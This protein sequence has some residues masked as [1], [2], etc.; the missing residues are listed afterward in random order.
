[1]KLHDGRFIVELNMVCDGLVRIE[2]DC[3]DHGGVLGRLG[4][5]RSHA[6]GH[7][8]K[9]RLWIFANTSS[10]KSGACIQAEADRIARQLNFER[11]DTILEVRLNGIYGCVLLSNLLRGMMNKYR[12]EIL[13]LAHALICCRREIDFSGIR[14][15]KK[16]ARI[17]RLL[18]LVLLL[19]QLQPKTHTSS[20]VH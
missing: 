8:H 4:H 12:S 17:G 18:V 10:S 7:Q 13:D 1:M 6:L 3:D 5:A 14:T 16:A 19:I 11:D 15:F 2:G 9:I 20:P